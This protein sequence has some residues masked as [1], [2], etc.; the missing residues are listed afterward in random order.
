M[1][2]ELDGSVFSE[3]L[4]PPG[5]LDSAEVVVDEAAV[6]LEELGT[7]DALLDALDDTSDDASLL[8]TSDDAGLVHVA[9]GR[10]T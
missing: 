1:L 9:P 7:P 5:V 4:V 8:E 3:V 10:I 6:L 2:P